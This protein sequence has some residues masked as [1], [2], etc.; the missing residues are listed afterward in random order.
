MPS[1]Q[2]Q[3]LIIQH[4]FVVLG[5]VRMQ[6]A[7]RRK[8][9]THKREI[10]E[11][12]VAEVLSDALAVHNL[13]RAEIHYLERY[14]RGIQDVLMRQKPVR[15]EINNKVVVNIANEIVT[16]KT[17]YF[18]GTPMQYVSVGAAHA[19]AAE[20]LKLNRYM[21]A[22]DRDSKDKEI[23]DWFHICGV[24]ER[25]VLP[26]TGDSPFEIFTIDPKDAFVIYHS[27][28]GERPMAGVIIQQDEDGQTIYCVYTENR[29]FE[30]KAGK[31]IAESYHML[32]RVPLIEYLNN[33]ARMGAF[34]VVLPLLNAINTLES[35][36]LDDVEQFVQSL[37]VFENCEIDD[38]VMQAL[39]NDLG[40]MIKSEPGSPAK[41]YR[42]DGQLSQEG[43][44]T[45]KD[46]L[47]NSVLTICGMPN[48]NG[49]SSTS[50][51]GSAVALR[52]GWESA[53]S[54]AS[55][56]EKMFD[57][58]DRRFLAV[59]L[60]ICNNAQALDL[61]IVDIKQ[62]HARNNLSNMQ[63]RMQ[64]LCEALNNERIHPKFA[65]IA[66]GVPNAEEWYRLSEQYQEAE[67]EKLSN[68]LV[69]VE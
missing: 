24:S 8:V 14:Y 3:V 22:E 44:Q 13:N 15:P 33:E 55:D 65:W 42:V 12:N 19:A 4:F 61:N 64:I 10:N 21:R 28:I 49:G 18:I 68:E 56:T 39:K 41:V 7:G 62:E 1:A 32:G 54:R 52:D 40:L 63:S 57:R 45:I 9:Y 69:L 59:V 46:D 38:E 25:L 35:N 47:Y 43:A 26:S 31:V 36:R 30:I 50:D 5:V 34:E 11:S 58:A 17:A 48:R 51:T 29:Y 60:N 66:A 37:M 53:S 2:C 20:V 67:R 16:F 23:C 27:G 6:L